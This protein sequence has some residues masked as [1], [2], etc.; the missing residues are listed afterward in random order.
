MS[1]SLTRVVAGTVST[2]NTMIV[3]PF[4]LLFRKK[5]SLRNMLWRGQVLQSK[6]KK[7]LN[8]LI[9]TAASLQGLLVSP[10]L[11]FTLVITVSKTAS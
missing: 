10:V 8:L 1:W 7:C 11:K 9:R 4:I 3:V 5:T 2:F 6:L